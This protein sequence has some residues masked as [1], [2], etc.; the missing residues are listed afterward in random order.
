VVPATQEAEIGESQSETGLYQSMR[1]YL[2][3][4]TKSKRELA[5]VAEHL[6]SKCKALSSIPIPPKKKKV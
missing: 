2:K 4:Q 3:K 5:Q 1:L 6:P